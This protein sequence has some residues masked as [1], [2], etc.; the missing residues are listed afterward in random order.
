MKK[1]YILLFMTL[2]TLGISAATTLTV[3]PRQT[4]LD[5][6]TYKKNIYIYPS[7]GKYR[8]S[9][10]NTSSP[11]SQST[12]KTRLSTEGK[13]TQKS[14]TKGSA[15]SINFTK[16]PN[17]E[18]PYINYAFV[19]EDEDG[20]IVESTI[21]YFCYKLE[22]ADDANK[23]DITESSYVKGAESVTFNNIMMGFGLAHFRQVL[24]E[25][26]GFADEAAIIN[27]LKTEL[28]NSTT[29]YYETSITDNFPKNHNAKYY[30]AYAAYKGTGTGSADFVMEE[31]TFGYKTYEFDPDYS[32]KVD[33]GNYSE[34][35]T[36]ATQVL[37]VTMGEDVAY[38]RYAIASSTA[39]AKNAIESAENITATSANVEISIG[40]YNYLVIAAYDEGGNRVNEDYYSSSTIF[41][42]QPQNEWVYQGKH[43][44]YDGAL[45]D[46][47]SDVENETYIVDVEKR[48]SNSTYRIKNPY[49]SHATKT[50]R[51]IYL[52]KTTSGYQIA[53]CYVGVTASKGELKLATKSE[54]YGTLVDNRITFPTSGLRMSYHGGSGWD[55]NTTGA[56]CLDLND[57]TKT[58]D[59]SHN[60][61]TIGLDYPVE[62]PA[63]VVAYKASLD[64]SVVNLTQFGEEGDVIP[65]NTGAI[66][67]AE[68]PKSYNFVATDDADAVT[69]NALKAAIEKYNYTADENVYYLGLDGEKVVFKHL[70]EGGSIAAGKAY[71]LAP[72]SAAKLDVVVEGTP[73]GITEVVPMAVKNDG[74]YNIQGVRVNNS[75][76]GVVIMNG[77]KYLKK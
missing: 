60:W 21:K 48:M 68:N 49:Q 34:S 46:V 28:N 72:A 17:N 4:T 36:K 77:K 45:G 61:G 14:V 55:V 64:G 56:F 33:F 53:N 26:T 23:F 39:N 70:A 76:K 29:A 74:I 11:Y 8:Y 51:Y 32:F 20:N 10:V 6:G 41:Y 69:G 75:F 7:S 24:V 25:D 27:A 42:Y 66:L 1:I 31:S 73:T 5:A 71:L 2:C 65:A 58:V 3:R 37:N 19:A 43:K 35:E 18:Y 13:Y 54:K 59:L 63:G 15:T 9:A 40:G 38:W 62:I 12:M 67:Y 16:E 44:F 52:V 22:T 30:V 47:F 50:D 57:L